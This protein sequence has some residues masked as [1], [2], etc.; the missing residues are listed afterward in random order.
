MATPL[1]KLPRDAY[2]PVEFSRSLAQGDSLDACKEAIS[3]CTEFLHRQFRAGADAG[4]LIRQRA[5]F[6]DQMLGALWDN[7][8]WDDTDLALVA[9]GGYG[10]GELHPHSDIDILLLLGDNYDPGSGQIENFL[11]TLWD[12]GL[13]IGHSVRTVVQCVDGCREDITILT[14]LMEARVLRGPESLMQDCLLYT[15]DA[16]DDVSTV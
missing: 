3:R 13:D 16:A 9:V 5:V 6:M 4:L 2:D 15:S 14:N 11:T 12:I 10:R 7:H 8:G 1:P